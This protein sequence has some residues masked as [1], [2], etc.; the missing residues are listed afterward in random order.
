MND[1]E[2]IWSY[3][4]IQANG[5]IRNKDGYLIGRLRN[6]LE[7]SSKQ[8]QET[9]FP[10]WRTSEG[11]EEMVIPSLKTIISHIDT[12]LNRLERMVTWLTLAIMVTLVTVTLIVLN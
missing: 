7:F 5:I 4:E 1:I 2:K 3:V 11:N 9:Q 8:V 12:R 10:I 6:N